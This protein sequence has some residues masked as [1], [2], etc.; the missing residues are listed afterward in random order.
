MKVLQ[1]FLIFMGT[2]AVLAIAALIIGY[3]MLLL[4]PDTRAT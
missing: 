2:L 4:T 1:G 3:V